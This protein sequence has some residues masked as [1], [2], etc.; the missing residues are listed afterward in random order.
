MRSSDDF[1]RGGVFLALAV[2]FTIVLTACSSNPNRT[3]L[4]S[5]DHLARVLGW[6][7]GDYNN[8]RQLAVLTKAGKPIWR[9]DG[10]GKPGH[11]EVTS[12]YR[13]V[14]LPQFGSHVLY[15]EETKHG[16]PKLMFRQR[17][18]TFDIDPQS[19]DITVKLWNFKDKQGY[20]GAY[21][22][23]S[24][25]ADLQPSEMSP[26]PDQCD[27][28]IRQQADRYHMTMPAKA[29]A[30][31]GRYFDYQVLLG[32]DTFWFRDRIVDL[33]TDEVR[34][35]AGGFTYHELDQING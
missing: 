15:V 13:E 1:T 23:L 27:L 14:N 21:Q 34:E 22:D 31:G 28:T 17:I 9:E 30:F 7:P 8:D 33:E 16:D 25:I 24:M 19:D 3:P 6:W 20:V 18:Y 32:P 2:I 35:S 4:S 11:I 26:L 12:H 29:C 10:S 5:A